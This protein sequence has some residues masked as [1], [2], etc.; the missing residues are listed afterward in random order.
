MCLMDIIVVLSYLHHL[1]GGVGNCISISLTQDNFLNHL[2]AFLK[3]VSP[4]SPMSPMSP[5]VVSPMSPMSP[6]HV[7]APYLFKKDK[8]HW[9]HWRHV[10]PSHNDRLHL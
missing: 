9:R 7:S 2:S 8:R 5:K 6:E 4:M 10:I 1:G 3:V